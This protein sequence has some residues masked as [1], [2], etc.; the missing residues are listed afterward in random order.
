MTPTSN[1]IPA[2]ILGTAMW[3]WTMDAHIC[4][5]VLD[6]F[7]EAGFRGVDAATNYPIN[8]QPEDFRLSE[9]ILCDWIKT[10]GV[11]D[12]RVMMKVG[13]VDNMRSPDNN[14]HKSFL[15]MCLD[16]YRELLGSNLDMLMI[17]WDNREDESEIAQTLEALALVCAAGLKVGL[18]GIRFPEAYAKAN[19]AFNLDFYIQIKH[20]LLQSDYNK[21][22]SFHGERRFLAY[23]INAG[24][25][26]LNAA[27][28]ASQSSLS[29]RGGD[30]S[31]Q[32]PL[33]AGL[34][35]WLDSQQ[36][37]HVSDFNQCS[38]TYAYH[39]EDIAGLLI[40]PSKVDQLRDTIDFYNKLQ[41]T[42]YQDIYNQL[43]EL[44]KQYAGAQ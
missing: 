40:G 18:S 37:K 25:V 5:S 44:K 17:H 39:S 15:L 11:P 1:D 36:A 20:N 41:Q 21:Y 13:S 16:D 19:E 6:T 27:D 26:K 35:S 10:H 23:G 33:I 31:N 8:R 7:Y 29:V 12:L 22:K 38:M 2:L 3:G 34:K 32:S 24:G 14:L 30:T 4:F 43:I 42:D 9:R 28:Y